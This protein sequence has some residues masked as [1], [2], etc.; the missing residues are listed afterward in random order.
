MNNIYLWI[1]IFSWTASAGDLEN[2]RKKPGAQMQRWAGLKRKVP[3]DKPR[4]LRE[5]AEKRREANFSRFQE[6]FKQ[7]A[8]EREAAIKDSTEVSIIIAALDKADGEC[9]IFDSLRK[10]DECIGYLKVVSSKVVPL[11]IRFSNMQF[12]KD[13]QVAQESK[14]ALAAMDTSTRV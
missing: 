8:K 1:L 11:R 10:A 4:L 6:L 7:M 12:H 3:Q 14:K 13:P 5:A 2:F 9:K